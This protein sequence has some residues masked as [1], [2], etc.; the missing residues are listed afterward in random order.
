MKAIQRISV[1][2]SVVENIKEAIETG[3]YALGQKLPTEATLC[4]EMRVSRTS[5]REALR[6]LQAL[7]YVTVK[8]GKGAFASET[9]AVPKSV[10]L[11]YGTEMIEYSDFMEVR[12]MV[13]THAVRLAVE[14]A[15]EKQVKELGE[16]HKSFCE[17]CEKQE[18]TK[19]VMLDETFH[20]KII[21]YT[22]NPLLININKQL[23]DIARIIRCEFSEEDLYHKALEP[24][25]KI[26]ESF[27][28]G[29]VERAVAEMKHHMEIAQQDI[30]SIH[31]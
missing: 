28:C 6:V 8:P 22:R 7:G 13:E 10:K 27:Q 15:T 12:L 14:R 20:S 4:K 26:L 3:E 9:L 29:D 18:L 25:G 30:I 5:V 19:L 21:T 31:T 17:A 23:A 24:H 11:W 2:D 1:T 16:I